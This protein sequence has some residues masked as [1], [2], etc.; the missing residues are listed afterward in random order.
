MHNHGLVAELDKRL[1]ERQGLDGVAQWLVAGVCDAA[2]AVL[3]PPPFPP[4]SH[5]CHGGMQG[6]GPYSVERTRGRRRVPKPPTRISPTWEELLALP[7]EQV[8]VCGNQR[9]AVPFMMDVCRDAEVVKRG[10][11]KKQSNKL[12]YQVESVEKN[13]RQCNARKANKVGSRRRRKDGQAV[14]FC[15]RMGKK[16]KK[17]EERREKK[18][19]RSGWRWPS[20][21]V[22]MSTD[23]KSHHAVARRA[24][25]LVA[26]TP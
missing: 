13:E 15:R 5:Q 10:G 16:K 9:R 23:T 7:L 6:R 24:G 19:G 25:Y 3:P 11:L 14:V 22:Q 1:G 20:L 21:G 17:K 8:V 18:A 26:A 4:F 12:V 2:F